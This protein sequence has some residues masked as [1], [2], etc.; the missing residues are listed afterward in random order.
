MKPSSIFSVR[1]SVFAIA[2]LVLDMD[3][4]HAQVAP[5]AGGSIIGQPPGQS[6]V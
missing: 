3:A 5:G 2:L 4:I 1:P 6:P